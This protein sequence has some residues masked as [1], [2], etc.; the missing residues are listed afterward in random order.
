[1]NAIAIKFAAAI[2]HAT[3]AVVEVTMLLNG[4]T[5]S[6]EP[7]AVAKAVKFLTAS[8]LMALRETVYDDELEESFAYMDNV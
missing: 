6:G 2:K 3:N 7:A 1:M 8:R 5:I 4:A